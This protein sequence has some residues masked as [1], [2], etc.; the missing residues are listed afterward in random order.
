M[1]RIPFKLWFLLILQTSFTLT[2]LLC[3]HEYAEILCIILSTFML[4]YLSSIAS[5][6]PQKQKYWKLE[7]L[8]YALCF[9][10]I[11]F[12]SIRVQ[13]EAIILIRIIFIMIR[14][15]KAT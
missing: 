8:L 15:A 6:A 10:S 3:P 7:V 13:M 2:P 11:F 9:L 1:K 12:S 5:Q 4:L 14:S